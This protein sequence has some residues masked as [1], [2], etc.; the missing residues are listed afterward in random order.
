VTLRLRLQGALAYVLLLAIVALGVPLAINLSARVRAEVRTQAQAQADLVAATAADLLAPSRR[1]EL[2]TL[3]KT[4]AASLRGRILVVNAA[5]GVL[6]DSAGPAEV[7]ASYESRPEIEAALAGRPVQVQ[8]TS[9]T[10]GQELLATAVPI[11][12]NGR[13]AG[14]VRVTQSI[15]AVNSAVRRAELGLVLIA[16]IVLAMG[17]I[18]G[19]TIAGQIGRPIGRL[20]DVAQRVAR[21]ELAA[22]AEIAG[23]REQ[24]SL[25]VSFN[26]MTERIERLLKVQREFVADASHQLRTPL[27]GLRLR[28]EEASAQGVSPAAA[29]ELDAALREVD[30]LAHTVEELLALSGAGERQV[31]GG[32]VDLDAVAQSALRRGQPS[33]NARGIGLKHPRPDLPAIAW[34]PL[35]DVERALDCLLENAINYSPPGSTVELVSGRGRIEV[36]DRGPGLARDERSAVFERFHRGRAGR[37]GPPGSGLGLAIARELARTWSGEVTV[38]DRAGGGCTA[39]LTVPLTGEERDPHSSLRAL[40][41][42]PG[43]FPR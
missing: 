36:R 13:P 9:R 31:S 16:L 42:T 23:S 19:A 30:R 32:P 29:N 27:T 20:Q 40:N 38:N 34:A 33:A 6:V 14:A 15:A 11:I 7:G 8:R 21:G 12:R 35:R 24:R 37:S 18:A 5:G 22:R 2:T 26:E 28:L 4:A 3:A 41:P 25:A 10:L 39:T 17:L 43:T 1:Q